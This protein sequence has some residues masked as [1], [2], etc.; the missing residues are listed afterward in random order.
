MIHGEDNVYFPLSYHII[1]WFLHFHEMKPFHSDK[2]VHTNCG[3]FII[4]PLQLFMRQDASWTVVQTQFEKK[5][6]N[7]M[8]KKKK[9]PQTN[10]EC[11]HLST[12]CVNQQQ[13]YKLFLRPCWN[14]QTGVI[15][16]T[17]LS[18]PYVALVPACLKCV[19]GPKLFHFIYILHRVS[20]FLEIKGCG[21]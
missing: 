16:I 20:I 11:N 13:F 7:R 9:K 1:I 10:L 15:N 5:R 3:S 2:H 19:P 18:Q 21:L 17:K 8:E 12:E 4:C 14:L 6:G